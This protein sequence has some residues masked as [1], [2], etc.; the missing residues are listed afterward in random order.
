M[1]M[2]RSS[3]FKL[4]Q[5]VHLCA[6][7]VF[8]PESFEFTACFLTSSSQFPTR[9]TSTGTTQVTLPDEPEHRAESI[10]SCTLMTKAEEYWHSPTSNVT[11]VLLQQHAMPLNLRILSL[12]PQGRNSRGNLRRGSLEDITSHDRCC[13]HE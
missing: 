11:Q 9:L 6:F 7:L 1:L 12:L 13:C 4:H 2:Q 8:A 5:E 3:S 10:T